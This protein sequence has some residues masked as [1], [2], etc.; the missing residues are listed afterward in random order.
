MTNEEKFQVLLYKYKGCFN[1]LDNYQINWYNTEIKQPTEEEILEIFNSDEYKNRYYVYPDG[2]SNKPTLIKLKDIDFKSIRSIREWV[3]KQQDA[4]QF[5][6]DYE[7]E[8]KEER[9]KLK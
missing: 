9:K 3:S 6:K 1:I 7:D 2:N 8:A 5:I 4:P